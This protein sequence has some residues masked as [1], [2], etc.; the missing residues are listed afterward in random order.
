M[1][2]RVE[3]IFLPSWQGIQ[4]V[5]FVEKEGSDL[6]GLLVKS[7]P[8]KCGHSDQEK[9]WPCNGLKAIPSDKSTPSV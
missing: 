7:N 5:K 6:R 1:P 8:L 4:I 2:Q 3:M 9:C